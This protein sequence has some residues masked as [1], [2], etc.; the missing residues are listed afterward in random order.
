MDTNTVLENHPADAPAPS[1]QPKGSAPKMA[2]RQFLS[3]MGLMGAAAVV[4]ACTHQGATGTVVGSASSTQEASTAALPTAVAQPM[5]T[6]A[7]ST[8]TGTSSSSSCV[9]RCPGACSYPG[10]CKRYTDTNGNGR[11]DLGECI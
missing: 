11:C 9:Q 5:P 8:Q 10:R 6:A 7:A 4:A 3:W 2:R 1:A